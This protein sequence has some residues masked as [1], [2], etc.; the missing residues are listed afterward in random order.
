MAIFD[1]DSSEKKQYFSRHQ[2]T[3]ISGKSDDFT[4]SSSE[5]KLKMSL[6]IRGQG[7]HTKL[8]KTPISNKSS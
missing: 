8:G 3:A 7:G 2:M 1:F 4:G 6:L 5:K